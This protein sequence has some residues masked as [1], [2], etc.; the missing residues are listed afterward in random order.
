MRRR[1]QFPKFWVGV[2]IHYVQGKIIKSVRGKL[3]REVYGR[4]GETEYDPETRDA[5]WKMTKV[6]RQGYQWQGS[7]LMQ[8]WPRVTREKKHRP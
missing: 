8:K 3:P 1:V 4:G 6:V 5:R 7:R 2:I